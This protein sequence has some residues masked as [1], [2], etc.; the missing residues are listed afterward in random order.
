MD[1]ASILALTNTCV[2]LAYRLGVLTNNLYTIGKRYNSAEQ[3]ARLIVSQLNA[4]SA[5]VRALNIWLQSDIKPNQ[6]QLVDEIKQS[7]DSC[8]TLIQFVLDQLSEWQVKT[9][10]LSFWHR[11]KYLWDEATVMRF[12]GMLRGQVQALSLLL[13]VK[14]L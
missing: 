10:K 3:S 12:E 11:A 9:D 7:L 1:P 2:N 13:Q 4:L 14:D 5:A 8:D 6:L